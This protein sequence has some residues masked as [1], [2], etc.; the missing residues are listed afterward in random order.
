MIIIINGPLGIGKTETS[1]ELLYLFDKAA[2]LDGD[3]LGAVQPFEIYNEQRIANLYEA[4]RLAAG[5]HYAHGYQNLVINYVFETP[6][7]LA[8]LHRR[9][10]ELDEEIY[11]FRLTCSE[12]EIAR[13]VRQR[14]NDPEGLAWEL[15]RFRELT[16][17]QNANAQ[18]GDLGEVVD[19]TE[20][21]ARETARAIWAKVHERA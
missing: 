1:W 6:E 21:S 15:Q 4:L 2:M 16:E 20:L 12:E 3:Y 18:R 13:R 7:S 19:T 9:L 10:A 8:D 11:V 17:I 5:L 14:S